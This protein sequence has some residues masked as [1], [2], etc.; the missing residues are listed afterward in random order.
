MNVIVR[1]G[2]MLLKI[3]A[4]HCV[5]FFEFLVIKSNTSQAFVWNVL[6]GKG[7]IQAKEKNRTKNSR[8]PPIFFLSHFFAPFL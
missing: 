2:S 6:V 7:G 4:N 3:S 5:E 1:I 8:Q